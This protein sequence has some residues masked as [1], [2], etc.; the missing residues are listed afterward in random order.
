MQKKFRLG[1]FISFVL[2]ILL[3]HLVD[4]QSCRSYQ[5]TWLGLTPIY[6]VQTT[7]MVCWLFVFMPRAAH[8]PLPVLQVRCV[9]H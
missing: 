2:S 3:L 5:A 7:A 1:T 8:E 4:L 9:P 6:L